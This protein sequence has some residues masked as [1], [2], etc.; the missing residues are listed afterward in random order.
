M[1]QRF[2]FVATR[3]MQRDLEICLSLTRERR[4][5]LLRNVTVFDEKRQNIV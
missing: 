1:M 5:E 2:G 3:E 4:L